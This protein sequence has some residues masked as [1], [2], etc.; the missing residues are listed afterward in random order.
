VTHEGDLLVDGV[1]VNNLPVDVMQKI[2]ERCTIIGVDVS[3]EAI[4]QEGYDFDPVLSGWQALLKKLNPLQTEAELPGIM[5]LLLRVSEFSS[6]R[7][8]HRQYAITETIIRPDVQDIG[9][10]QFD[11]F[12]RIVDLGYQAGKQALEDWHDRL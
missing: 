9:L 4:L 3:S 10:F 8:K 11:D 6:V 1:L 5:N 12:E 2:C 7:L